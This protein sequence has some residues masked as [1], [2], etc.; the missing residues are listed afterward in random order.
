MWESGAVVLLYHDVSEISA[1]NIHFP[2]AGVSNYSST[3]DASPI[4][5]S[6]CVNVIDSTPTG[7]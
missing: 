4:L 2:V 5:I 7:R 3:Y 6:M 1:L